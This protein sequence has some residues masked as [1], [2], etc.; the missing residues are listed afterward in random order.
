M[1]ID[2]VNGE[3]GNKGAHTLLGNGEGETEA[4]DS[5]NKREGRATEGQRG[6]L[7]ETYR[8]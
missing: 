5:G 3:G 1:V 8:K 7:G 6:T 4:E 2:E